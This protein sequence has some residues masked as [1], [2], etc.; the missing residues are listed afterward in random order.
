MG[1]I[2]ELYFKW[3]A[4]TAAIELSRPDLE[5]YLSLDYLEKT[6]KQILK[7]T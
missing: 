5:D 6:M 1:L 2:E 3:K 4:N 7:K